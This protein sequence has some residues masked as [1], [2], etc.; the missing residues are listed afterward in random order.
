MAGQG[1]LPA[2]ELVRG[3]PSLHMPTAAPSFPCLLSIFKQKC[4]HKKFFSSLSL[5]LDFQSAAETGGIKFV[6]SY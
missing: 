5:K 3:L 2:R 6:R 4:V 1:R